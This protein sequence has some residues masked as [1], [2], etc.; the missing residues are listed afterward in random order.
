MVPPDILSRLEATRKA[1][2]VRI[3]HPQNWVSVSERQESSARDPEAKGLIWVSRVTLP[4][5]QEDDVRQALFQTIDRLSTKSETYTKPASVPVEGEWVGHRHNVDAQAPEPALTE[6]EKYDGLMRDVSSEVTMLYVHGG[7]FYS[8]SPAQSRPLISKLT[9]LT[10]GRCFSLKY[11]L[12]PQH[13]FPSALLDLLLA[14][15]SLLHPQQ[16]P[17]TYHSAIPACKLVLTGDSVGANLCLGL[18]QTILSL[19]RQQS[20]SQPVVRWNGANVTLPLPQGVA[21]ISPWIDLTFSLPSFKENQKTDYLPD[22]SIWWAP[23]FPQCSVWPTDPPRSDIYCDA[24]CLV[25]P[26]ANPAAVDDWRG[27][28]PVLVV[29]GEEVAS[30]GAKMVVQQAH[31]QGVRIRWREFERLPHVFMLLLGGLEHTKVAMAEWAEFCTGVVEDKDHLESGGELIGVRDLSRKEV[32][33]ECLTDMPRKAALVL[34]RRGME[35]R[36]VVRRDAREKPKI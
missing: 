34:M 5:P 9:T 1:L 18:I 7:A 6:R 26:L 21:L 11:R 27:C 33:L 29:C 15:L 32:D 22:S 3:F 14:Y 12:S 16:A 19:A 13:A 35:K 30:D 28:P 10:H 23:G 2:N 25:H 36:E 20:C 8:G 17:S 24:S 31:S 4:P